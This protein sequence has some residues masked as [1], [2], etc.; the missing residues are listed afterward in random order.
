MLYVFCIVYIYSENTALCSVHWAL[1]TAHW[2]LCSVHCAVCTG[3]CA[4]CTGH[5]TLGKYT[6]HC[7]L[8]VLNRVYTYSQSCPLN[9]INFDVPQNE[10]V[11]IR[12]F[13]NK[14]LAS[15]RAEAA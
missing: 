6:D 5:C 13:T 2:A 9:I 7:V 14:R 12:L 8:L 15:V 3:H 1:G 11:I 10:V 4:V